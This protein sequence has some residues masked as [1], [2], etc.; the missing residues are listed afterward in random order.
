LSLESGFFTRCPLPSHR[1]VLTANV[2]SAAPISSR[3]V[4]H[5]RTDVSLT[6]SSGSISTVL[7]LSSGMVPTRDLTF[8]VTH[9]R[10]S[11]PGEVRV[12]GGVE[13]GDKATLWFEQ[14]ASNVGLLTILVLVSP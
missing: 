2:R 11:F 14:R 10:A 9:V 1:A 13:V 7:Q 3:S 6:G 8:V 5:P 12:I 4:P